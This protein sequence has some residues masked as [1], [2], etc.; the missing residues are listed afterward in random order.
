MDGDE[1]LRGIDLGLFLEGTLRI[2]KKNRQDGYVR[3]EGANDVFIPGLKNQNRALEGDKVVVRLLEGEE[4]ERE[5]EI[6]SEKK[7]VRAKRNQERQ[8]KVSLFEQDEKELG[9]SIFLFY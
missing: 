3:F 5:K 1:L 8:T 9:K 7:A 4:L 2:N 6:E